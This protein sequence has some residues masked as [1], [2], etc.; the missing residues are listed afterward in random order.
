VILSFRCRDTQALFEGRRV[1][2]FVNIEAVAL[3]KLQQLHAA[4]TLDFLRIPPGNQLEPL[5][6][7]RKGQHSI[8]ITGQWRLCFVWI[9]GHAQQ[10]EIVDYH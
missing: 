4:T 6:H 7:D 10:V 2:R 5:K 8:K 3:R 9:E 1:R